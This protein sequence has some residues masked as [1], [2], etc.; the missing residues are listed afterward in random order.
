MERRGWAEHRWDEV[1]GE[2]RLLH[3]FTLPLRLTAGGA[4]TR[5]RLIGADR[6]N[7]IYFFYLFTQ[8]ARCTAPTL[9][10]LHAQLHRF[11]AAQQNHRPAAVC[12]VTSTNW[13]KRPRNQHWTHVLCHVDCDTGLHCHPEEDQNHSKWQILLLSSHHSRTGS[14]NMR[15][16]ICQETETTVKYDFRVSCCRARLQL[17]LSNINTR[18]TTASST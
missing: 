6:L 17:H 18:L 5:S 10:T 1:R 7:F 11:W 9:S 8:G 13:T 14:L 2:A 12:L 3:T 15:S 16:N 4:G